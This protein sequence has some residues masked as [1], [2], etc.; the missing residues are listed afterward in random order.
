M[1]RKRISIRPYRY[2]LGALVPAT[3]VAGYFQ[4]YAGFV[5]PVVMLAALGTAALGGGR[6]FCGHCCPRGSFL[7]T[8]LGRLPRRPL[9][10]PFRGPLRWVVMAGLLA[11]MAWRL[12]QNPVDLSHWGRVFWVMC[13][14]TTAVALGLAVLY[15]PRAWCVVCPVGSMSTLLRRP[16][17]RIDLPEG[18]RSCRLCDKVCSVGLLPS[19]GVWG[20]AAADCLQC[21]ACSEACPLLQQR[22]RLAA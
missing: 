14:A 2:W 10:P 16:R 21:G 18:C 17:Y 22:G 4:P 9:P 11:F 3:L 12:A 20:P 5:V 1:H 19:Q 8:W 13:L 6:R 15:R 7:D